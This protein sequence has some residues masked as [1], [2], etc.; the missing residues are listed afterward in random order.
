MSDEEFENEEDG[1][2]RRE[3][4]DGPRGT[5]VARRAPGATFKYDE[6]QSMVQLARQR[7]KRTPFD[8]F[9]IFLGYILPILTVIGVCVF[10]VL[11]KK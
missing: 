2:E 4:S 8:Y 5:S 6:T 11:R 7:H 9:L 3:Y 10:I 1:G